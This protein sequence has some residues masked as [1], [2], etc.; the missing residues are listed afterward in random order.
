MNGPARSAEPL[1]SVVIPSYNRADYIGETIESVLQQTYSN[2]EVVVI[3][4]GSTDNTAQVVEPFAPRVRYI[5]QEN[6]ERGASRNHGLRLA[7]GEY[8]AFLDS[9]DLWLPDKAERG[10][11]F[12]RDR[13]GVGMLCTDAIE[14]D[15]EGNERRL[16]H[17]RGYSGKVTG[18]LL[19]NNFVIMPTH[20]ARTSVVR[21]IGGFREER[22]LSGSED[23]EM[24][25]RLSLVAEIAYIPQVTA[26]YRVHTANTMSSA[27]GMQRSMGRAAQLFNES[28]HLAR[29]HKRSLRKMDANVALVNA[30]NYCS[31]RDRKN[32][33]QL[34]AHAFA[35]DP[36]TILDP[37]FG[38]TLYRLAKNFA[39]L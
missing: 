24:W 10:I 33:M 18:K 6:A 16:L 26:K 19:Q 14:I 3:D 9:D 12:L 30:I 21:E 38:Y 28:E 13:P 4:D 7:K 25:V 31:Q 1:L 15:G 11:H 20:L 32:S 35:S 27:E 34:L 2:I 8:I 5:R 22:K 36:Q 29:T 39:R 23:W 17:A 37:R